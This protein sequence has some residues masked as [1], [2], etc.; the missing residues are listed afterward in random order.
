VGGES[1][2]KTGFSAYLFSACSYKLS[3]DKSGPLMYQ[4]PFRLSWPKPFDRLGANGSGI[5]GPHQ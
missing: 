1:L 4:L 2:G 3:G 5:K